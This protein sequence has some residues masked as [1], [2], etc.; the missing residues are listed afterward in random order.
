MM[1]TFVGTVNGKKYHDE[2]KFNDAVKNAFK[3]SNIL[4]IHSYYYDGPDTDGEDCYI[5]ET[6]K[7]TP[8]IEPKTLYPVNTNYEVPT[9][10]IEKV[11]DISDNNRNELL[12]LCNNKIKEYSEIKDNY[13]EDI[14]NLNKKIEVINEFVKDQDNIINYYNTILRYLTIDSSKP[15]T[16][17]NSNCCETCSDDCKECDCTSKKPTETEYENGVKEILN[18]VNGFSKYLEDIGFWKNF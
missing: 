1:K 18:A 15:N 7:I 11:N 16:C 5:A 17:S 6:P 12:E 10:F 2:N 3:E 8:Y 9:E 14:K 13:L 4:N